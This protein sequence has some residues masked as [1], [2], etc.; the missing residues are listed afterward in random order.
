[1]PVERPPR[2]Q[3]RPGY[4]DTSFL[5]TKSVQNIFYCNFSQTFLLK[6]SD[7]RCIELK[8]KIVAFFLIT[9]FIFKI[10]FY[11]SITDLLEKTD[12]QK[13]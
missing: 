5:L 4:P 11:W 13:D 6:E 2:M 7:Y 9:Y 3:N 8:H 10:N 1:M 12:A